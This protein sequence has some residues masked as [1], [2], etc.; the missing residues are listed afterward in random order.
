LQTGPR[1]IDTSLARKAAAPAAPKA[2]VDTGAV[3]LAK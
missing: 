2:P 3:P 1:T